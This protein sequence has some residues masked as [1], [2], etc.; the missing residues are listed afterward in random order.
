MKQNSKGVKLATPFTSSCF[1]INFDMA[2]EGINV[3]QN[4]RQDNIS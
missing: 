3:T 1:Q 4:H 2:I